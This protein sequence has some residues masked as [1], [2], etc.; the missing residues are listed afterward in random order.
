[1]LR[2][3]DRIFTNLYGFEDVGLE[4]AR[5]RGDWDDTRALIAKGRDW[6]V[7][8][9]KNSGLRGRGGAGFGTGMKWSFMPKVSD[10]RPHYLVIN[11]DEGEPGTCK[12]R[13]ILRHEPHKLL[14]GT[15]LAAVAM[16]A[17]VSYI[18]I[19]GEFHRETEALRRAIGEAYEAGLIGKNA[20]GSDW[21]FDIHLHV[22]AGAYIC[23]EETALLES[24]EVTDEVTRQ[25]IV[26][27]TELIDDI[28]RF[29]AQMRA[30]KKR[31][32]TAVAASGT[33]LCDIRGIGPIGAATILGS[34]RDI[35]RFPSKG[36]FASYNATAPIDASSANKNRHRLNPRGN[37]KLNHVM[38]IAAVSQLR[39][40]CE[41]RDYY[42]KKLA[43]GKTSKEAI[44]A[45][46]RRISD[47]VYQQLKAD[48][49]QSSS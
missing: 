42:Q 36:H 26:I 6:I 40:P 43:E 35:E 13:E 2:D 11:A 28:A 18:Y 46:K 12:D 25:R 31:I 17:N 29:E 41:G 30:S 27:A 39:Y 23:G 10:G 4:G 48:A 38:H 14:E 45:L 15:L 34:V 1:M 19:R 33:S 24:L 49:H 9:V 5:A 8:E 47:A 21:D 37:R 7:D 32:R 3:S 22:G 16:G 44:R 20:C